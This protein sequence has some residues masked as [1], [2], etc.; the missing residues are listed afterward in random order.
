MNRYILIQY[1]QIIDIKQWHLSYNFTTILKY[2]LVTLYNKITHYC[3]KRFVVERL[4]NY[5]EKVTY[6][7]QN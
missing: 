5:L 3:V 2:F 4:F 7:Q 6:A 1:I